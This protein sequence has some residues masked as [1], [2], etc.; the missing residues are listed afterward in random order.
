MVEVTAT[1]Q[2]KEKRIKRIEDSLRDICNIKRMKIQIIEVP[3]EEEKEKVSEKIFEEIRVKNFPNLG[4]KIAPKS[5]KCTVPYSIN[6]RR[7]TQRHTLIKLTKIK[8]NG[9]ILK[10]AREK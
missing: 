8:I 2:N 1:E 10:A 5:R 3:E 6:L 9:K 4:K 7:N